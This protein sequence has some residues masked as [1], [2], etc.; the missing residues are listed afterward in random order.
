MGKS[1]RSVIVV[2]TYPGVMSGDNRTKRIG[3]G[4]ALFVRGR[5]C[6][7]ACSGSSAFDGC[8]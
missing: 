7:L 8:F 1:G 5:P 6:L 4:S 2:A 3:R